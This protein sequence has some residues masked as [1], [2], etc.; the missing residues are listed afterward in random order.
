MGKRKDRL[1]QFAVTGNYSYCSLYPH[2]LC[3]G[4]ALLQLALQDRKRSVLNGRNH[5][6]IHA[7]GAIVLG[8]TA[9]DLWLSEAIVSLALPDEQTRELLDGTLTGKYAQVYAA[10]HNRPP[11]NGSD[12]EILVDVRHEIVHHFP[13]PTRTP[14]HVPKWLPEFERQG[15]VLVA[16]HA[17]RTKVD[18]DPTQKLGSYGLAYWVFRVIERSVVD[19]IQDA[20]EPRIQMQDCDVQNFALY[21][22]VCPPEELG[23]FDKTVGHNV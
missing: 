14:Q 13:R 11:R 18:F 16:E 10:A 23:T 8:V 7:P 19:V 1:N 22:S 12:L 6:S 3:S 20:S 5:L 2:V 21:R 15:I 4:V 9:L 17:A